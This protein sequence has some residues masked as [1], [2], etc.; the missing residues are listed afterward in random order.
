MGKKYCVYTI[1]KTENKIIGNLTKKEAKIF[2]I[3][4][5]ET[6]RDVYYDKEKARKG[7]HKNEK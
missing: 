3:L 2:S 5:A 1:G 4:L 6:F 7:S